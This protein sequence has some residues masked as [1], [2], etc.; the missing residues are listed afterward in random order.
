VPYSFSQLNTYRTCPRQYEF[1]YIKK[2]SRSI[3]AGESF[4][5]SVHNTLSKW[6][7]IEVQRAKS[8][9]QRDQ[10]TL[11]IEPDIVFHSP[12]SVFHLIELW[13]QSFIVQGYASKVD[14]DKARAKGEVLMKH[15]FE[16]WS[17][18]PRTVLTVETGFVVGDANARGR[19]DRVEQN[20]NESHVIDFKTGGLRTQEEVDADLQ[21]SIYALAAEQEFGMPCTKLTLMFLHEDGITEVHTS[22]SDGQLAEAMQQIDTLGGGI[23]DEQFDPTPSLGACGRCPYKGVCDAAILS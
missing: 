23:E 18:Q 19:F 5:S 17:A 20:G 7:K 15:F 3:S 10:L 13:H 11:F 21:L 6:G 2:I 14:G 12:L 4:G 16:W 1:G 22:R 9:V 8:K